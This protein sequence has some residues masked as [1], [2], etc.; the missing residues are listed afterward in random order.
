M[1]L[2]LIGLDGGTVLAPLFRM[3]LLVAVGKDLVFLNAS[4][5]QLGH[6]AG[7][8][9]FPL[10]AFS[11]VFPVCMCHYRLLLASDGLLRQS[12]PPPVAP[13]LPPCLFV[14]ELL[15]PS[16]VRDRRERG[17]VLNDGADAR[18][19]DRRRNDGRS[20]NA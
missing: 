13:E 11:E 12:R 10:R 5:V 7:A 16:V 18:T 2:F 15:S 3:L 1:V 9:T 19:D 4:L 14:P 20:K 6:C 8:G 17:F